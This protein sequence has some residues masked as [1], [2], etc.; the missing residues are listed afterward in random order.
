MLYKITRD[1]VP[2]NELLYDTMPYKI[3]RYK[4]TRYKI[5][6]SISKPKPFS[7]SGLLMITLY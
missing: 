2:E 4:I 7:G 1:I 5:T 3:A 6:I